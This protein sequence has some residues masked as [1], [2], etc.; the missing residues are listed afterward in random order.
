MNGEVLGDRY[1]LLE[2]VGEGGMAVVYKARCNKLNRY[3][4]VKILKNEYSDNDEIVSKFKRE[5]TAIAKLS[6]NN[7]VNVLDVGTQGDINYIVMEYVD[8]K[9]LKEVVEEFGKISCETALT[10]AIQI[11][12]ALECAHKNGIIHRDIKPQN[13]LVTSDGLVKV[14]DFGIAKI[15][16]SATLTNTSTILGS[17]HYFSPEQAKGGFIDNKTDIYSLGIVMYEML[18]GKLPFEADSPVTIALKHLQEDPVPPKELNPKIPESL[19]KVVLKCMEKDANNRYQNVNELISDLQKIKQNPDA[20]IGDDGINEND[21]TVEHTI[22]MAPVKEPVVESVDD[23]EDE[24]YDDDDA[25]YYDDDDEY[26]DDSEEAEEKVKNKPK[27]K[28]SSKKGIII[29][30]VSVLV[31]A[32]L[33]VGGYFMLSG[34]KAKEVIVPNFVGMNIKDA[35]EKA[36]S[37]KINLSIKSVKSNEKEGT[38]INSNPKAGEKINEGST[39]EVEVSSEEKITMPNLVE[40]KLSDAKAKLESLGIKNIIVQEDYSD[41]IASG[42]VM[43][44]T[45]EQ[46]Q[47]VTKESSVTLTVSKGKKVETVE[48][49]NVNGLSESEARNKLAG[50]NVNV[51]TKTTTDKTLDGKVIGQNPSAGT[52]V[53]KGS[54]ITLAIGRYKEEDINVGNIIS[55]GMTGSDAKSALEAKGFNVSLAGDGEEGLVTGWTPNSAPKGSTITITT[56]TEKIS[57]SDIISKGMKGTDAKSALEAKGFS[58]SFGGDGA[59]GLVTGWTPNSAPKG[60]NITIT[61]KLDDS[62]PTT[63]EHNNDK[64]NN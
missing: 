25:E 60:S 36:T 62:K 61:T 49:P 15:A 58:V 12:K 45:P 34:N 47:E 39:V 44:Q 24:Y 13:I 28:K 54:T 7:I 35:Q 9:T 59:E 29:G 26:Y 37:L 40:D 42:N 23:F 18:T 5:A 14:T 17:A 38:I 48:V 10:I 21:Q 55:K 2:K 51:E 1:E 33:G 41:S 8:G 56:K 30:I 50:F 16:D 3:V 64:K 52:S 32:I 22:I 19:N 57:I 53:N 11:A 27:N 31:L 46:G 20:Q 43:T 63:G 6:H 4:A